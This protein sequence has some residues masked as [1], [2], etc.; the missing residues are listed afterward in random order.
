MTSAVQPQRLQKMAGT[1]Q[2]AVTQAALGTPPV[3]VVGVDM[4]TSIP[5]EAWIKWATF[6]YIVLQ[7]AYLIYKWVREHNGKPVSIRRK[8]KQDDESSPA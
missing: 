3:A 7:I 8:K 4:L 6:L 1:K 5:V 2:E